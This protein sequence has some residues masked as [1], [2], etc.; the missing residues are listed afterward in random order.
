VLVVEKEGR[1]SIKLLDF[2]V[3]KL[4]HPEPAEQGLTGPGMIMGSVHTMAPEQ[5]LCEPI[6]A[7]SDIYALG[8]L[9]YQLLTGRLPFQGRPEDVVTMHLATQRPK[10]SEHAPV[11]PVLD[12]VVARSMHREKERRYPSVHAFIEDLR[13]AV[14]S[15]LATEES[16]LTSNPAL[17]L[18]VEI[19]TDET[20]MDDQL[21]DDMSSILDLCEDMLERAGFAFP[22]K[23]SNAVL[24]VKLLSLS[25]DT[26]QEERT[27]G[28]ELAAKLMDAFDK[29]PHADPRIRVI[30]G[31]HVDQAI[32]RA[33]GS[34][35]DVTGGR[36]LRV[37]SWL[38]R[39]PTEGLIVS[40]AI[41]KS[42]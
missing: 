25:A 8:V 1:R 40:D 2:G 26:Q 11:P 31:L 28:Q 23:N 12:A 14:L 21:L 24:G 35:I 10:P 13:R 18:Y 4:L 33:T 5:I 17:G 6:D 36:I 7:R 30:V 37:E 32:F 16:A 15:S 22:L 42:S 3:A 39:A 41:K 27:R 29:R 9:M 19:R 38:P 20:E 34:E